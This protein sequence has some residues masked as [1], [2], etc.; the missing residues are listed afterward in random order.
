MGQIKIHLHRVPHVERYEIGEQTE[1]GRKRRE[2]V[3]LDLKQ[4]ACGQIAPDRFDNRTESSS[5]VAR[6]VI[7]FGS[8]Q[9]LLVAT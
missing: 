1:L 6:C 9:S 5:S 3:A 4:H 2:L 8:E 7:S